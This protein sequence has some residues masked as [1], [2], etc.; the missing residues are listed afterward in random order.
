MLPCLRMLPWTSLHC[1]ALRFTPK[2][3]PQNPSVLWRLQNGL[4]TQFF[5]PK[6]WWLQLGLNDLGRMQCSEEVVVLGILRIVEEIMNKKPDAK[7]VINS[8]LPMAEFR[9]GPRPTEMDYKQSLKVPQKGG[10]NKERLGALGSGRRNM[11]SIGLSLRTHQSEQATDGNDAPLI[12]YDEY[13]HEYEY[14][15]DE[16]MHEMQD[17]IVSLH[18]AAMHR[19]MKVFGWGKKED[20]GIRTDKKGNAVVKDDK[21]EFRKYKNGALRHERQIP[22]WTSITAINEELKK[23]CDLTT[24]VEFFD[25]TDIFAAKDDEKGTWTLRRNL[26]TFRGRPT[27]AGYIEWEKQIAAK[28]KSMI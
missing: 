21:H 9:R 12:G 18:S 4:L 1:I 23:F 5:N 15:Y 17:G 8:L 3:N 10:K 13:D 11:R 19:Q 20:R 27:H 24:N 28:V 26:I 2:R 7:I 22:L 6:V 14:E 16:Y 25:A